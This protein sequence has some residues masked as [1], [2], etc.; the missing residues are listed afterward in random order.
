MPLV[1][2]TAL[3]YNGN[4]QETPVKPTATDNPASVVPKPVLTAKFSN[5]P[6]T[7]VKPSAVV[8]A[9]PATTHLTDMKTNLDTANQD[10]Q[11]NNNA[12]VTPPVT[13]PTPGADT[14][15]TGP[16]DTS[17]PDYSKQIE[18]IMSS[19]GTELEQPATTSDTQ[20]AVLN[21]DS[22]IIPQLQDTLTTVSNDI[23][24]MSN[25]TYPLTA[26]EQAQIAGI[27]GSFASLVRS[28][29][30]YAKNILA[31][32]TVKNAGG[33]DMYS[34]TTAASN[35]ATAIKAGADKIAS[36]NTKILDAQNKATQTIQDK[37]Y[38]NAVQTY[39][40]LNDLIK[41]RNDEI[42]AIQSD[43][44]SQKK[45][46]DTNV[47]DMAKMQIQAVV[48]NENASYK[49]KD[50]AIKQSTL[51]EKTK[52]D[53]A[54]QNLNK[55]KFELDKVNAG[56]ANVVQS[57]PQ[58]QM[59]PDNTVDTKAQQDFLSALPGGPIGEV[60]TLVKGIANYTINPNSIPTRNYRGV[61]GLTQSQVVA[62]AAQYDPSFNQS[63]YST[64]QALQKNFS[65]GNY[66]KNINSL[67]TAIGHL[68]DLQSN[69]DKLSNS[70]FTPYNALKNSIE[71]VFGAGGITSA[72][73][74]ISAVMGELASTFKAGGAT[75]TEIKN[76]GTV[77]VNSSP[78]QI[79]SFIETATQ[80]LASR[81]SALN[82]T[83]T[84][85]MGKAPDK[86][87]LSG[88]S[89]N[90][91]LDLQQK[92]YDI[93]VPD[94]AKNPTVILKTFNDS[95]PENTTLLQQLHTTMPNATP[96]EIVSFLENNGKLQ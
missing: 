33:T 2:P 73:T 24:S 36:I 59:K 79:K 18:D 77:D 28:A 56:S 26:T 75:D 78:E 90:K 3:A 86:P 1:E 55:L 74:N 70:G 34:P 67:N 80:L 37:D 57:L 63:Q 30:D 8:T 68:T 53:L 51:D 82:D 81:L 12:K 64:R 31:G 48:D 87:F 72:G 76:L 95:A 49:D 4:G 88:D 47:R 6:T 69:F 66:S 83:Y 9:Q 44:D 71:K 20:K 41:N 23:T 17:T 5:I 11:N 92:G 14:S 43:I 94:L 93:Q 54:T 46:M 84:S 25:G 39:T 38:K 22:T 7:P 19:L 29:K 61:G 15:K 62:M 40:Q 35:I 10:V 60:A 52:N 50:L 27:A 13:P 16:T 85:G 21:E 91:L 32:M 58:V 65:S 42:K 89:S 96:E 45:E